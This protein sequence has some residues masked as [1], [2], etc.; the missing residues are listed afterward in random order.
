M[1]QMEVDHIDH[2]YSNGR[3]VTENYQML[4]KPCNR[5]KKAIRWGKKGV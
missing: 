5:R 3:T 2:W 1:K 4:C